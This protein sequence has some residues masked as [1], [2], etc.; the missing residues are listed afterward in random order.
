MSKTTTAQHLKAIPVLKSSSKHKQ[1][2]KKKCLIQI[3]KQKWMLALSKC[4]RVVPKSN[5]QGL[6]SPPKHISAPNKSL[7]QL[8]PKTIFLAYRSLQILAK[9]CNTS[10]NLLWTVGHAFLLMSVILTNCGSIILCRYPNEKLQFVLLLIGSVLLHLFVS[11][12]YPAAGKIYDRSTKFQNLCLT[13]YETNINR[14]CLIYKYLK[15]C[16]PVGIWV[17]S[18][19]CQSSVTT[20]IFL[21]T[22]FNYTVTVLLMKV[23]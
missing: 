12:T 1:C 8:K 11:W 19:Y 22:A 7:K 3:Y 20:L 23:G 4:R 5:A 15:S 17:G 10:I 6:Q 13:Y 14:K 16:R 21:H 2:C 18:L 9:Q